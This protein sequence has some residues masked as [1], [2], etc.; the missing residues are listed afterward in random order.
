LHFL[1]CI[2]RTRY[3]CRGKY[4]DTG[5]PSSASGVAVTVSMRAVPLSKW[6]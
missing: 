2:K 1:S 3:G 4:P 6:L 5:Q